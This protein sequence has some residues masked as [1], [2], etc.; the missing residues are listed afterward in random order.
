MYGQCKKEFSGLIPGSTVLSY[1]DASSFRHDSCSSTS[2]T[3]PA[4]AGIYTCALQC[5]EENG[6]E[7]TPAKFWE[8]A[9]KT[10]VQINDKHGDPAG[11]AIDAE[12]LVKYI[13]EQNPEKAKN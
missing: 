5:A 9:L 1:I 2:W 12:A 8:Y 6:I 13:S 7:L 3:V 11:K 10:G 4:L